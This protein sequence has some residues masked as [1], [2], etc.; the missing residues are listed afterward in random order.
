[1]ALSI[2]SSVTEIKPTQILAPSSTTEWIVMVA[3]VSSV[4]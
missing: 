2:N 3:V 1:M 4:D